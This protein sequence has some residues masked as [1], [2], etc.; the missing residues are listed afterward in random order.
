MAQQTAPRGARR[1]ARA[2]GPPVRRAH[3]ARAAALGVAPAHLDAHRPG[4]AAPARPGRDP[5]LG[6]PAER[7]R[8]AE[9]LALADRPPEADAGLRAAQPLLRLRLPVVRGHLPAAD[10]LAGRLHHPAPPRLLARPARAA[11]GRPAEPVPAAGAH[12]V[13]RRPQSRGRAGRGAPGAAQDALPSDRLTVG[14]GGG[15]GR[16]CAP[17][18]PP[19]PGGG[20]VGGGRARVPPRGRQPALPPRGGDRAGGLRGGRAV[21]LQGRRDPG[22]GPRV[23]QR[24]HPVRRLRP[25]LAV[26][27]GLD[28]A[29]QLHRPQL[30]RGLDRLGPAP[31]DGARV[32]RAPDLPG[33]ARGGRRT[34]TTSRSTTR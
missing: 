10:D 15:P 14:R 13:R 28:G 30:R 29:V 4:A 19:R 16:G 32:R 20:R 31:G 22:R 9:D 25:R 2:V 7:R 26:R 12:V 34:R 23:H 24:A 21:R 18:R 33:R 3:R 6:D 8:L 5:G 1:R 17:G 11:T 27:P